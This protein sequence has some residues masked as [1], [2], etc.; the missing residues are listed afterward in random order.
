M[1][2]K[3][4]V[5]FLTF[6][7]LLPEKTKQNKTKQSKTK[8]NLTFRPHVVKLSQHKVILLYT[9]CGFKCLRIMAELWTSYMVLLP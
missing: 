6:L 8:Q 5:Y 2:Y 1:K 3:I 9:I 4:K 7:T